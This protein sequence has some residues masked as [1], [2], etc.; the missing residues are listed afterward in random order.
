VAGRAIDVGAFE[1]KTR[2]SKL[3]RETERGKSFA[4]H[5]RGKVV[6]L[7]VPPEQRSRAA[8]PPRVLAMFREIRGRVRGPVGVRD[9]IEAGRRR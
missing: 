4:I 2:L 9:L 1:A 7:L 3:L 6:A 5:R 8:S